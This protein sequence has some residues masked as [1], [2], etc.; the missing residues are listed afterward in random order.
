MVLHGVDEPS[1]HSWRL[2]ELLKTIRGRESAQVAIFDSLDNSVRAIR[3]WGTKKNNEPGITL[4]KIETETPVGKLGCQLV[5]RARYRV[6]VSDDELGDLIVAWVA[7][8]RNT[9]D[10]IIA[11]QYPL[12]NGI[13][14][15]QAKEMMH[16]LLHSFAEKCQSANC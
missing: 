2:K 9:G 15:S 4:S 11:A 8:D 5:D 3:I 10:Q 1:S 16:K 7:P 12:K 14:G 6:R 13:S